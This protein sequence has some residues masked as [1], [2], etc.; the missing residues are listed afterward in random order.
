MAKE[1]LSNISGNPRVVKAL[2]ELQGLNVSV[3]TGAN[4]ATKIDL[5]AIRPEDTVVSAIM[6][7]GGVPSDIT[8]THS[9]VDV[10]ATGTLTVAAD[11]V[12]NGTA[13]VNGRVFTLKAAPA[14]VQEVALGADNV[15]TAVNLA[16]AINATEGNTVT[17]SANAGVVTVTANAE[18]TGGN[19]IAL[20]GSTKITASGAT[21]AGGTATGGVKFSGST[22]GNVVV[23]T[24]FNKR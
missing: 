1:S 24:W 17:A 7:T 8:N 13:T 9:I 15:A 3:L 19:S 10:R 4:A 6:F 16:A 20:V 14:G 11:R 22:S 5:A 21:L 18:G 23:L 2:R 12:A